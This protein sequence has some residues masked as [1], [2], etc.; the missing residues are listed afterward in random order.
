MTTGGYSMKTKNSKL[1]VCIILLAT[2]AAFVLAQERPLVRDKGGASLEPTLEQKINR[3]WDVQEIKKL[4]SRY[5]YY[6]YGRAWENVPK[7]FANRDDIWIDCEGFGIFDGAKGIKTFFVDWHHSMEGD[8]KGMFALHLLTTDIIEVAADGRTARGLWMS[9]GAESRRSANDKDKLEAI[10]IW[11]LYA[12]DFIKEDGEWKFWHFRIPHLF[13]CDYHHSW[14][15]LDKVVMGSQI[16]ND[17]RP[18]ADRP[19][20]FDPTFFGSEKKTNM[21]FEPPRPYNTEADLKDF[22]VKK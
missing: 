11:G 3:L 8:G 10:W 1:W 22:W 14:I 13:L 2:F 17:G 20:S 12:V 21:F 9:P 5:E 6:A 19:P 7:M 15:E 18:K 16:G 4:M